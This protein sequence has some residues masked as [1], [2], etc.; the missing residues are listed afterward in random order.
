MYKLNLRDWSRVKGRR[1]T[2]KSGDARVQFVSFR[3]PSAQVVSDAAP[4]VSLEKG[5]HQRESIS[6]AARPSEPSILTLARAAARNLK[7]PKPTLPEQ[8]ALLCISLLREGET[9]TALTDFRRLIG[10]LPRDER[11]Y[12]I[13]TFYTL[14]LPPKVRRE[15]AAYFTP[16]Y[17]AEAV[18]NLAID[19]GFDPIRHKV[20]DPAAGGAAFL[21]TVAGRKLQLGLTG[22]AA[23]SGLHGIEIDPGLAAISRALI[24]DRIGRSAPQNLITVCDALTTRPWGSYDLIVANP[25]YGRIT[26]D[27]LADK[28]WQKVAY[29]GHINKYAVFADFSL[30]AAK[31]G[32]VVALVIP[33]SFRAGPFY[34]LLR[35]HIRAH[36]E[37]L[38][39]GTVASR[40]GIFA[41]VAQDV[42]V[43]VLRKGEPHAPATLVSF[44]TLPPPAKDMIR[45]ATLPLDPKLPWPT[46]TASDRHIGGACL[47]DYGVDART[48]YFVW[49]REGERLVAEARPNAYPLVWAKNVKAGCLCAPAGKYGDKIDF[50]TFVSKSQAIIRTPAAVLQRTT[51]DKQPRRLI[52]ALVNPN[53]VRTWGG[54]VTENH[55]IVLTSK[56]FARLKLVVALLNTEA[57]DDRYRKVSGTAAI[58]VTLLRSLDL[59]PLDRFKSALELSGGNAEAAAKLAYASAPLR[60]GSKT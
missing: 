60:N 24:A 51:N 50:V 10:S 5:I 48:G 32:G 30:K 4:E 3:N 14:L 58:S 56:S 8:R 44:P 19:A 49:N 54:F 7:L 20:L 42:S 47:A 45:R 39:I 17:L 26:P 52:G 12:W 18:I 15:Q 21:S 46:P 53:V 35:S 31:K 13:G 29:S 34:D 2:Y 40:D 27:D 59:P 36:A 33:S 43:I 16:P 11:Y 6:L 28:R 25:P 23:A 57:V 22:D 38:A 37:V 9:L 55:T 1:P 41:D